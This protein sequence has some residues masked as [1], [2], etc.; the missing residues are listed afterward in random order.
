MLCAFFVVDARNYLFLLSR[1]MLHGI[2]DYIFFVAI[3]ESASETDIRSLVYTCRQIRPIIRQLYTSKIPYRSIMDINS[4]E[5][6]DMKE[7]VFWSFIEQ[8]PSD[9]IYA[10]S[11]VLWLVELSK[12]RREGNSVPYCIDVFL[13]QHVHTTMGVID[14]STNSRKMLRIANF[15]IV[16]CEFVT[17]IKHMFGYQMSSVHEEYP[18][19]EHIMSVIE[20]YKQQQPTTNNNLRVALPMLDVLDSVS[21]QDGAYY[22]YDMRLPRIFPIT[23]VSFRMKTYDDEHA[24]QSLVSTF[25]IDICR[26]GFVDRKMLLIFDAQEESKRK[27]RQYYDYYNR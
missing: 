20:Q 21:I 25:D 22:K 2:F 8:I 10:G 13:E 24:V 14:V 12:D 27:I 7:A 23:Q 4:N 9:A 1:D 19:I 26:I 16:I 3:Q 18:S 11:F 15:A 17:K 5:S 6:Q